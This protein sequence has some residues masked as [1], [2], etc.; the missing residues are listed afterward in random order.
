MAGKQIIF[1]T[2][3]STESRT[4]QLVHLK[5]L[6][7]PCTIQQIFT[8]GY[9]TALHVSQIFSQ[10]SQARRRVFVVGNPGIVSE[11]LE[12]GLSI[13]DSNSDVYFEEEVGLQHF[14]GIA[15]GQALHADVGAVVVGMDLKFNYLKLCHATQYIRN[16]AL[17]IA[18]NTDSTFP[19]FDT[20]FPAAGF[21]SAALTNTLGV[22]PQVMGKPSSLMMEIVK[23][24]Y[25]LDLQRVCMVGDR[26]DTD[27]RFGVEG[28]LGGTL[29]VLTGVSAMEDLESE[30]E[31]GGTWLPKAYTRSLSELC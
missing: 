18:T 27:I 9:C 7:V 5:D 14:E 23:E 13:I 21:I 17:F 2:N 4:Q 8:S 22:Q 1:V 16:G 15:K 29:L 30:A 19:I 6:D 31:K 28:G 24:R 10:P 12:A 11:L 3:N 26:L 25:K 20:V